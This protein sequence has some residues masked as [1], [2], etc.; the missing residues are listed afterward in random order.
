MVDKEMLAAISEMM[1]AKFDQKLQPVYDRLDHLESKMG[2]L[3]LKMDSL[4][5]RMDSLESRMDHL[6]SDMKVVKVVLL[7]NE[8]IPQLHTIT[9]CYM[10][11]S[12][13]YIEKADQ[14]DAMSE[15]ITVLQSVVANHSERLN[16]A[17]I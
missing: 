8:I 11:V 15:N 3:E 10:D 2:N 17:G 9:E 14:V 12:K 4:E 13:R 5:S 6:E 7:E 16:R 1:D